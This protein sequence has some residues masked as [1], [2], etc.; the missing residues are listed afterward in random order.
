MNS[1]S[2]N[3]IQIERINSNLENVISQSEDNCLSFEEIIALNKIENSAKNK[4][5]VQYWPKLL[6][7]KNCKIDFENLNE[8]IQNIYNN[9][10]IRRT[11]LNILKHVNFKSYKDDNDR[12]ISKFITDFFNTS[13]DVSEKR[14]IS[15]IVDIKSIVL[16]KEVQSELVK[17]RHITCDNLNILKKKQAI[18]NATNGFFFQDIHNEKDTVRKKNRLKKSIQNNINNI[19]DRMRKA[20][21]E[22]S[23]A[24]WKDILSGKEK[25]QLIDFFNENNTEE[26]QPVDRNNIGEKLN[27]ESGQFFSNIQD[28]DAMFEVPDDDMTD[29]DFVEQAKLKKVQIYLLNKYL[30]LLKNEKNEFLKIATINKICNLDITDVNPKLLETF[31][32]ECDF[33]ENYEISYSDDKSVRLTNY[34]IIKNF[35]NT[36]NCQIKKENIDNILEHFKKYDE[37]NFVEIDLEDDINNDKCYIK[38]INDKGKTK[39]IIYVKPTQI[40]DVIT[41][42]Y[43]HPDACKKLAEKYSKQ[44]NNN[45]LYHECDEIKDFIKIYQETSRNPIVTN[46]YLDVYNKYYVSQQLNALGCIKNDK[47]FSIDAN[48]SNNLINHDFSK[49]TISTKVLLSWLK[50]QALENNPI[51]EIKVKISDLEN[52]PDMLD[53]YYNWFILQRDVKNN[54]NLTPVENIIIQNSK[55]LSNQRRDFIFNALNNIKQHCFRNIKINDKT[56]FERSLHN[57]IQNKSLSFSENFTFPQNHFDVEIFNE[58]AKK[59]K[60]LTLQKNGVFNEQ[61]VQ[62]YLS[63]DQ[64]MACLSSSNNNNEIQTETMV[65]TE[66]NTDLQ[67]LL[68]F[69]KPPE[70]IKTLSDK[71]F[72]N[73]DNVNKKMA[74]LLTPGKNSRLNPE[75]QTTLINFQKAVGKTWSFIFNEVTNRNQLIDIFKNHN[76]G[77]DLNYALTVEAFLSLIYDRLKFGLQKWNGIQGDPTFKTYFFKNA[78]GETQY[79]VAKNSK[80]A[81]LAEHS[82][83]N[84]M[85]SAIPIK[86]IEY[87][88]EILN[89]KYANINEINADLEEMKKLTKNKNI[90]NVLINNPQKASI[91]Y[92]SYIAKNKNI[93]TQ[94]L[95]TIKQDP[96]YEKICSNVCAL[97]SK[98]KKIG[99]LKQNFSLINPINFANGML[100]FFKLIDKLKEQKFIT[101]D[102]IYFIQ[103]AVSRNPY[104]LQN[105]YLFFLELKY[106]VSRT[107]IE[108]RRNNNV[109]VNI[110]INDPKEVEKYMLN[111]PLNDNG[112]DISNSEL[113]FSHNIFQYFLDQTNKKTGVVSFLGD[114]KKILYNSDTFN[115]LSFAPEKDTEQTYMFEG[116]KIILTEASSPVNV[117][118]YYIN[119]DHPRFNDGTVNTQ[120]L[121]QTQQKLILNRVKITNMLFDLYK[122]NN[123]KDRAYLF[124]TVVC[125]ACIDNDFGIDIDKT[126]NVVRNW[127]SAEVKENKKYIKYPSDDKDFDIRNTHKFI[128]WSN[129]DLY[130]GVYDKIILKIIREHPYYKTLQLPTKQKYLDFF[131]PYL[132]ELYELDESV[133]P[134]NKIGEG[135]YLKQFKNSINNCTNFNELTFDKD[136][137]NT[138][139]CRIEYYLSQLDNANKI[140]NIIYIDDFIKN[141]FNSIQKLISLPQ[142]AD[143]TQF[144]VINP[145]LNIF[146]AK[147]Y[148]GEFSLLTHSEKE[149]INADKIDEYTKKLYNIL[150]D[151]KKE[152]RKEFIKLLHK[153]IYLNNDITFS[154]IISFFE[155]EKVKDKCQFLKN[156]NVLKEQAMSSGMHFALSDYYQ[157][158]REFEPLDEEQLPINAK[159]L[160]LVLNSKLIDTSHKITLLKEIKGLDEEDHLNINLINSLRFIEDF[161]K[162]N[163]TKQLVFPEDNLRKLYAMMVNNNKLKE[164]AFSVFLN[165]I[166]RIQEEYEKA[167]VIN[168]VSAKSRYSNLLSKFSSFLENHNLPV[169]CVIL[170]NIGKKNILEDKEIVDI[171]EYCNIHGVCDYKEIKEIFEQSPDNH[172]LNNE[173]THEQLLELTRYK[174]KKNAE[175]EKVLTNIAKSEDK[176]IAGIKKE[177]PH[178]EQVVN[179]I[180]KTLDKVKTSFK[181]L[182]TSL[183]DKDLQNERLLNSIIKDFTDKKVLSPE[184]LNRTENL[185]LLQHALGVS[186]EYIPNDKEITLEQDAYFRIKEV[187]ELVKQITSLLLSDSKLAD[188]KY[189]E[190]LSKQSSEGLDGNEQLLFQVYYCVKHIK[191]LN[192]DLSVEQLSAIIFANYMTNQ[193]GCNRV[194]VKMPTGSGKTL[195]M[196]GKMESA[197]QQGKISFAT[198]TNQ[199]LVDE[200]MLEAGKISTFKNHIYYINH[201]QELVNKTTNEVVPVAQIPYILNDNRNN[202][203]ATYSSLDFWLKKLLLKE[204]D[205]GLEIHDILQNKGQLCVDEADLLTDPDISNK[206]A[207]SGVDNST[208]IQIKLARDLQDA[209]DNLQPNEKKNITFEDFYDKFKIKLGENEKNKL[210]LAGGTTTMLP[211]DFAEKY[212]KEQYGDLAESEI[213]KACKACI[214]ANQYQQNIHYN[215]DT[216]EQGYN[217]I[218][219]IKDGVVDKSGSKYEQDVNLALKIKLLKEGKKFEVLADQT[220]IIGES[221][222]FDIINSFNSVFCCSGTINAKKEIWENNNFQCID[223]PS[224]HPKVLKENKYNSFIALEE[225]D[226]K[227]KQDIILLAYA[228]RPYDEVKS[229][230]ANNGIDDVINKIKNLKPLDDNKTYADL[231]EDDNF[232]KEIKDVLQQQQRFDYNLTIFHDSKKLQQVKK[233]LEANIKDCF[234]VF[235]DDSNYDKDTT[236]DI[237]SLDS[238]NDFT[239]DDY[240]MKQRLSNL[241]GGVVLALEDRARGFDFPGNPLYIAT[242]IDT[243]ETSEQKEGRVARYDRFGAITY[244]YA[245]SDQDLEYCSLP[246]NFNSYKTKIKIVNDI[247][248]AKTE[249]KKQNIIQKHKYYQLTSQ[250]EKITF[251][252]VNQLT[253]NCEEKKD[254]ITQKVSAIVSKLNADIKL[255]FNYLQNQCNQ[256]D[257][258]EEFDFDNAFNTEKMKILNHLRQQLINCYNLGY[259]SS[260]Q[261]IQTDDSM[262]DEAFN[263]YKTFEPEQS[264]E[265]NEDIEDTEKLDI[266]TRNKLID[267]NV[268]CGDNV[269]AML[270]AIGSVSSCGFEVQNYYSPEQESEQNDKDNEEEHGNEEEKGN[271]NKKQEKDDKSEAEKEKDEKQENDK[272]NPEG[273]ITYDSDFIICTKKILKKDQFGQ[274]SL[275]NL[276]IVVYR[277]SATNDRIQTL[278]DNTLIIDYSDTNKPLLHLLNVKR[279]IPI[280]YRSFPESWE[281]LHK[282]DVVDIDI[283]IIL[284]N[285]L[286]KHYAKTGQ[287]PNDNDLCKY[288][289]Q[290]IY[291]KMNNLKSFYNVEDKEEKQEKKQLEEYF[292]KNEVE[293]TVLSL[294]NH[295]INVAYN[296]GVIYNKQ[297]QNNTNEKDKTD[298]KE[299]KTNDSEK[300]TP[301]YPD[302][303]NKYNPTLATEIDKKQQKEKIENYQKEIDDLQTFNLELTEDELE[304]VKKDPDNEQLSAIIIDKIRTITDKIAELKTDIEQNDIIPWDVKQDLIHQC[305]RILDVDNIEKQATRIMEILATSARFEAISSAGSKIEE[306]NNIDLFQDVEKTKKDST[307]KN[308]INFDNIEEIKKNVKN[309]QLSKEDVKD[310]SNKITQLCNDNEEKLKEGISCGHNNITENFNYIDKYIKKVEECKQYIDNLDGQKLKFEDFDEE[311]IFN[312]NRDLETKCQEYEEYID[313][314]DSDQE[315]LSGKNKLEFIDKAIEKNIDKTIDI[316]FNEESLPK[317]LNNFSLKN[318]D[319]TDENDIFAGLLGEDWITE[320]GKDLF[321]KIKQAYLE[322][323]NLEDFANTDGEMMAKQQ[324]D[325]NDDEDLE[326]EDTTDDT[327]NEEDEEIKKEKPIDKFKSRVK[328]LLYEYQDKI[329]PSPSS[330][331]LENKQSLPMK[332]DYYFKAVLNKLSAN[333]N[334]NKKLQ[335]E[336]RNDITNAI[337]VV[338][339][340]FNGVNNVHETFK[341]ELLE[342]LQKNAPDIAQKIVDSN[343]LSKNNIDTIADEM[344]NIDIDVLRN[345]KKQLSSSINKDYNETKQQ[346][347]ETNK[348]STGLK[349]FLICITFGLIL[350]TKKGQTMFKEDQIATQEKIVGEN[351]KPV[352]ALINN[353]KQKMINNDLNHN[354]LSL[355]SVKQE[356]QEQ[357]NNNNNNNTN[358][359]NTQSFNRPMQHIQTT[360]NINLNHSINQNQI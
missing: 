79:L 161:S 54:L 44:D 190:L 34:D 256:Q 5:V 334:K 194:F 101:D 144:A 283:R 228:L 26:K 220:Q 231:I 201:K 282:L 20:Q 68:N 109:H 254:E 116:E 178:Q 49:Y 348:T 176:I 288:L 352:S 32:K 208:D 274:M 102:H 29:P 309:K 233:Q 257:L 162:T 80:N 158:H 96:E 323:F 149:T 343:M 281:Y 235:L 122:K 322:E 170:D 193:A 296:T 71:D 115:F 316:V 227:Y 50:T 214:T 36:D 258:D 314:V 179:K 232:W 226:A 271:E 319:N 328:K 259:H 275:Q 204:G 359:D 75:L 285:Y 65:E 156:L 52:F 344:K 39:C 345:I 69:N 270:S 264:Q 225:D 107:I 153:T 189:E 277:D 173:F 247:K 165:N 125:E 252:F 175:K 151:V 174:A 261:P 99:N 243:Q 308:Y 13:N 224:T 337:N 209:Y 64:R 131:A 35:N 67:L 31:S 300:Y 23:N 293:K 338:S 186:S 263:R 197:R 73:A 55:E 331:A 105:L 15:E 357:Q 181:N 330:D 290:D 244:A 278:P 21:L 90:Q 100:Q 251:Y 313:N 260:N 106:K 191:D 356:Q 155:K 234:K 86:T 353:R 78:K 157:I 199:L 182:L 213:L 268:T 140:S 202:I 1:N 298:N 60:P 306:M 229:A 167:S 168:D 185:Q 262:V 279:G 74:E 77:K 326:D 45:Y 332:I 129:W 63:E 58:N 284:T 56:L 92:A 188:K 163:K 53:E 134:A 82:P 108:N 40:S 177:L 351:L 280:D 118:L 17:Y 93:L 269:K 51:N 246:K 240:S 211:S 172:Y 183:Y 230:I 59:T 114:T 136:W 198:T 239:Y 113:A 272:D 81:E 10:E 205:I 294:F 217:V 137:A 164:M 89:K 9:Q 132:Y 142:G 91:E 135:F 8:N 289:E 7:T 266:T 255:V 150:F 30:H 222:N 169:L 2:Y 85:F 24:S 273:T 130:G 325:N 237:L 123:G 14:Q 37:I 355:L 248:K 61:Q 312:L 4:G 16:P 11:I 104:S 70:E 242:E 57:S 305:D 206:I 111:N 152:D 236:Q 160:L 112:G 83:I 336:M 146:F 33:D 295:G 216:N 212:F 46:N 219:P 304:S 6:E 154:D 27:R 148:N 66:T 127:T 97:L 250:I 126:Y 335:E 139:E 43:H 221:S 346:I 18:R 321:N 180:K 38:E 62:S 88:N 310:I 3:D 41:S 128:F 215:V 22:H 207:T 292:G 350:L 320:D 76:K 223:I 360:T 117:L 297:T 203:F 19:L 276:N 48:V 147:N 265:P 171:I 299:G 307:W 25:N 121:T 333:F 47:T 245:I 238:V 253:K 327:N 287:I 340:S 241:N 318:Y 291:E 315:L 184:Q 143:G 210:L 342:N 192:K 28:I 12:Q 42:L 358:N 347:L 339:N 324:K 133:K 303:K 141:N 267:T 87:D 349:I 302:D 166:E 195:T 218:Y 103:D 249:K 110:D 341:K 187:V 301:F 119:K 84:Q 354:N 72:I 200:M 329:Y 196:L 317:L 95:E 311:K 94:F 145:L 159:T 138:K 120:G 98:E 124:A 286:I